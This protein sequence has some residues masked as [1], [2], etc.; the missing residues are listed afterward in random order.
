[1]KLLYIFADQT[2]SQGVL[3]KV[4]TKIRCL[5]ELGV[6]CKGL[7]FRTEYAA[8]KTDP[9]KKIDFFPVEKPVLP[10]IYR[11][12]LLQSRRAAVY[13]ERFAKNLFRAINEAV[14]KETFDLIL[15]RYPLASA[16]LSDF[17]SKYKNKVVFEHNANEIFLLEEAHRNNPNYS[18]RK[19][20]AREKEYGPR[21]ASNLLGLIAVGHEALEF[22]MKRSGLDRKRGTVVANGIDVAKIPLRTPPAF[23]REDLALLFLTGSPRPADGIDLVLRGMKA[24]TGKAKI[25]LS[26]VGP[27]SKLYT[28]LVDQLQLGEKV[29]FTGL[30][31]GKELDTIFNSCHIALGAMGMHRRGLSEHSVLK[32]LEYTARG[33][34]VALSYDETNFRGVPEMDVFSKKVSVAGDRVRMEEITSFASTVLEIEDHP[35]KMREIALRHHDAHVK[36]REL[37]NFLERLYAG[38]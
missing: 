30:L 16:E 14:E 4:E 10:S 25:T 18:T 32:T 24:Y 22:Q 9:A 29:S 36:M 37:K 23:N 15:F 38:K 2:E 12:R 34:P 13:T 19:N 3:E 5:N 6:D 17:T 35:A 11:S 20:L 33:I 21:C 26:V 8:H 1:M 31:R 27:V 28:D 7:F